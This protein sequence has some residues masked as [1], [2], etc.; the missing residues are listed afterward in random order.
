VLLRPVQ[1]GLQGAY[2]ADADRISTPL[3]ITDWHWDRDPQGLTM[4]AWAL[5]MLP[6]GMAKIGYPYLHPGEGDG[7]AASSFGL[8]GDLEPHDG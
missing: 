6:R 4:G 3:G 2:R 1:P 7:K 5:T 8:G